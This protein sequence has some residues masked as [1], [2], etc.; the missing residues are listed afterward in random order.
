MRTNELENGIVE[1][2]G[3][4]EE[5]DIDLCPHSILNPRLHFV[6]EVAFSSFYQSEEPPLLS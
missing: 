3:E 1:A 4:L 5:G 2:V 6:P